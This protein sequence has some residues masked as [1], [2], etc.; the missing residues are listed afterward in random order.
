MRVERARYFLAAVEAGSIRAAALRCGVSQPA[1]GQQIVMLEEEL[2]VVLFTRSTNGVRPTLAGQSLIE[3]MTRLVAA[4]DS[5]RNAAADSG[6]SYHGTVSIGAISVV[7]ETVIAPVVGQLREHHLDL[8]FTVSEASSTDIETRVIVGDLDFGVITMPSDPV[9]HHLLRF[10]LL[11]VSAG[12]LVRTDHLL[13]Q[14]D[15]LHWHD[16]E[17]WP[18]V[19]MQPGT[20]MWERLHRGISKPD[21]VV[22]AMS[23]RSVALMVAHGAGVGI[24]APFTSSVDLPGLR[25]IP[26]RDCEPIR[27]GL[28]Q[29]RDTQPSP[30]AL[31][32]RGLIQDRAAELLDSAVHGVLPPE[33]D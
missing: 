33:D 15:V 30:S 9:D 2:D 24:L 18:I 6:G 23:A 31:I 22:Q 1:L 28:V 20:V 17:T 26:L 25:W 29:R 27:I 12:A 10:P 21:V 4:E 5:V 13:A 32:V 16:L 11:A 14:R 3:P 8:R 19:A 7:A